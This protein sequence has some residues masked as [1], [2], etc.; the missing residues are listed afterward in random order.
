MLVPYAQTR[1][2]VTY[3][4]G[5]TIAEI[6]SGHTYVGGGDAPKAPRVP[7]GL[8]GAELS[9]DA[10]SRAYRIDRIVRGE[11]WDDKTRS[12]LTEMGVNVSEGDFILAVDGKP[13]RDMANI[14]S[15]LVGKAG[16]QVVLRVN[17]KPVDEGARSVTVVPTGN[18]AP[19]YYEAW[20]KQNT[21][22][23]TQKTGGQVGYIHIPDMGFEGL[24]EFAKHFYPQLRKKALIIDDRGNGGGFVSP[25]II[26]RLARQL[27]MVSKA[28]NATPTTNP[29]DMQLGPKLVLMDEF[30]A[31][32]GDIFPFRFKSNGLG[33]LIG[34]RSW[35]GVVGIRESLPIVDG[36]FI[37]KPEFAPYSKDGKEWP[38]EGHGVDPD[39]VVDNDP[40]K[41]F[42]GVD[43]QLDRGIEEILIELKTNGQTLPPPPPFPDRS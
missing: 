39:I 34:K 6:H 5:E 40:A 36:G 17:S 13:V 27:V 33:K 3:L 18:E 25:M 29:N 37:N 23:V 7:M 15:A 28:R 41:E 10:Q 24:D 30:S 35:G 26:E 21:D 12:P 2:D 19:L 43:Q 1:Y 9:R 16:K 20:V 32:D 4:I 8:L 38:V 22:Y 31:S 42:S 14:Y 11:N